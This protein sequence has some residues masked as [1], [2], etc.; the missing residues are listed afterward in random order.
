MKNQILSALIIL[1]GISCQEPPV[2]GSST[3]TTENI[4]MNSRAPFIHTVFF[5]LHDDVTSEQKVAFEG[6]MKK[7]GTCPTID[8]FRIGKPAMTPRDIV[9]N[10]YG[11]SWIVEFKTSADQD[12]Y[13]TEPIHLEFIERYE[14]LWKEV[15]VYDSVMMN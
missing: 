1:L 14:D 13:Q 3:P 15:K 12:A 6:G 8:N 10:S 11:Y 5:Y 7:L 4:N 2:S 9:D